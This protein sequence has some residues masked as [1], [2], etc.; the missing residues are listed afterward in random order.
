MFFTWRLHGGL[1]SGR[2]YPSAG[3]FG[4]AFLA[5]DRIL[6]SA[7]TGPLYLREPQIA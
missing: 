6:D 2:E 1:P 4:E 3:N 5:R 7:Q